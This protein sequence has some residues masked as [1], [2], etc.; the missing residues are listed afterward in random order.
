MESQV[1]W[2][3]VTARDPSAEALIREIGLS[4]IRDESDTGEKVGNWRFQGYVGA[5]SG[6]VQFGTRPDG[7]ILRLSSAA[8]AERWQRVA[9][10][11]VHCTRIDLCVTIVPTPANPTLGSEV[12]SSLVAHADLLSRPAR[13]RSINSPAALQTINVG[14]R[15]NPSYGRVYDKEAESSDSYYAGAWRFEVESKQEDAQ[16]LFS[17]LRRLDAPS[18]WIASYVARW[19]AK[20]GQAPLWDYEDSEGRLNVHRSE[21]DDER[22]IRWLEHS[23]RPVVLRLVERGRRDDI[24]QMLG[25]D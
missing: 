13:L 23:V 17:T 1:D 5:H 21:T 20:R 11:A 15:T 14:A 8:A 19:F 25:L 6:H 4:A 10:D 7:S 24:V 3:T 12:W 2:L 9:S 18:E 22:A 16:A